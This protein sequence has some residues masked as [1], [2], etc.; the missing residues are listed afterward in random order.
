MADRQFGPFL[1]GEKLGGGGMG[2]VYRA[3][4][5]KTGQV[6]ALKV[7]PP[8]EQ[9]E[10]LRARFEREIEIVKKLK[11]PNIVQCYGAGRQGTQQF[12]AMEVVDGG[13]LD[14][15]LKDRGRFP[16]QEVVHIGMQVCAA[17]EAAHEQGII[18]RDL[19]P[20][21][22]LLS[23]K[24][25]VKLSDFGIARDVAATALTRTGRT[26]GTSL[27]MAPE[28][29]RG[30]P[31]SHKADLYALGCVLFEFLTGRPPFEA[32]TPAQMFYKH[33]ESQ[34]PRVGTLA[35]DCPIWLDALIAQLLEKDPNK[36]PWDAMAVHQALKEVEE[37][38]A[39]QAS[40]AQHAVS[41]QPSTINATGDVSTVRQ[42]V[43]PKKQKRDKKVPLYEQTWFLGLCLAGMVGVVTWAMWPMNEEQLFQKAKQLM[44]TE[45]IG[46]WS[47][48]ERKFLLP[49]Q[50]KYPQGKHASEVQQY[51]DKLEMGRAEGR[52]TLNA[53]LGKEPATEGERLY[54]Q[55]HKF[56][57]FG[58][59]V[60]ALEKYRDM[61]NVLPQDAES[62]P[63]ANLARRQI[64]HIEQHGGSQEDRLKIL[65]A[66]LDKAGKLYEAGDT[67]EARKI[68]NSIVSLYGSNRELKPQVKR[69]QAR[70]NDEEEPKAQEEKP[71]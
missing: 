65:N 12:F 14:A 4:Y 17:L 29:I 21:N 48:A 67:V 50:A 30:E 54:V 27:Y 22:L 71:E 43:K 37:K 6:V 60:S 70:L 9:E 20:G 1:L 38:V 2:V 32:E 16:W 34:P 31:V 33:L 59:R 11:H 7:L 35:L 26:V 62:R 19:K 68:W 49:L 25:K 10:K 64:H 57:Q 61:L 42:L 13:A 15:I 69:A 40:M 51:L 56:E 3:T 47:D 46:L 5:V 45:D 41:G 18:H 52:I 55:A 53:K 39:N 63:F 58:D 24:G 44:E 66:A 23:K 8:G 36:R 28:Q